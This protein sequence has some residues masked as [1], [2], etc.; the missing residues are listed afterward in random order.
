MKALSAAAVA[1]SVAIGAAAPAHCDGPQLGT[2]CFSYQVNS[3]TTSSTGTTIRCLADPQQGYIWMIDTGKTQD[4][5][6]ADQMAWAA[7]HQSGYGDAQCR[8]I[9]DGGGI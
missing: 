6:I 4:P 7:C 3:T 8:K 2:N 9:L 1:V 5:W